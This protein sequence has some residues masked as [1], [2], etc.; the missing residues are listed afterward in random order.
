MTGPYEFSGQ[1]IKLGLP[2]GE[3]T[4]KKVFIVKGP[5]IEPDGWM[6]PV[7]SKYEAAEIVDRLNK[8]YDHL[9]P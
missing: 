7:G 8:L 4:H 9:S 3:F 5:E 1:M 2:Q 6:L